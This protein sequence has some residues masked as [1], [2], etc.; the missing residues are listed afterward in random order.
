MIDVDSGLFE[1]EGLVVRLYWR[2]GIADKHVL[3]RSWLQDAYLELLFWEIRVAGHGSA[4][5]D[6]F[7]INGYCTLV[8]FAHTNETEARINTVLAINLNGDGWDEVKSIRVIDSGWKS[9]SSLFEERHDVIERQSSRIDGD[10]DW[11]CRFAILSAVGISKGHTIVVEL[12]EIHAI[13]HAND[14]EFLNL[15]GLLDL[16]VIDINISLISWRLAD[17]PVGWVGEVRYT[18]L[19]EFN[20]LDLVLDIIH[21]NFVHAS[22]ISLSAINV[23]SAVALVVGV[24]SLKVVRGLHLEHEIAI[25]VEWIV[26][27]SED[28]FSAQSL[29]G[30]A[31]FLWKD[32]SV[33]DPSDFNRDLL[34][35][36]WVRATSVAEPEFNRRDVV[37]QEILTVSEL[38]AQ[39]VRILDADAVLWSSRR[40]S[41]NVDQSVLRKNA[42]ID[43][44]VHR[45]QSNEIRNDRAIEVDLELNLGSVIRVGEVSARLGIRAWEV[46]ADESVENQLWNKGL[47]QVELIILG[48]LTKLNNLV[49]LGSVLLLELI[50]VLSDQA[51]TVQSLSDWSLGCNQTGDVWIRR[52]LRQLVKQRIGS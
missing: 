41:L 1:D 46:S 34:V 42:L 33:I 49:G 37:I 52:N 8:S 18:S 23:V 43:G 25:H 19:G 2:F 44:D 36:D 48:D 22:C 17:G 9:R 15:V 10:H 50:N 3:N 32:E 47:E 38:Q 39:N 30:V 20:T 29:D 27:N 45:D 14:V 21:G 11:A 13:E 16:S 40:V 35:I 24:V 6:G 7:W 5:G 12:A 4:D 26:S 31:H 51:L 28:V